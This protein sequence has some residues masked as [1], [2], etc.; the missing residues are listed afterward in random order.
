MMFDGMG[1]MMTAEK[2][3]YIFLLVSPYIFLKIMFS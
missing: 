2:E 1:E 3:C